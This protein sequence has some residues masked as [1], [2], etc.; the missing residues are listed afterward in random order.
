MALSVPRTVAPTASRDG[1][2]RGARERVSVVGVAPGVV[3]DL[4]VVGRAAA[5]VPPLTRVNDGTPVRATR[6]SGVPRR[7]TGGP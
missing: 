7:R 3:F 1:V 2:A 6:S 5:R 4:E